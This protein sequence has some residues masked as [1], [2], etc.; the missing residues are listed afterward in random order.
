MMKYF[1]IKIKLQYDFSKKAIHKEFNQ[2]DNRIIHALTW[3]YTKILL[4]K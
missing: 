1:L 4:T 3:P 2:F